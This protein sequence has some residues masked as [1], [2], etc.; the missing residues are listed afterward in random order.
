MSKIKYISKKEDYV[1]ND[2]KQSVIK[3]PYIIPEYTGK[4]YKNRMLRIAF[5]M[6]VEVDGKEVPVPQ[7]HAELRFG[8]QNIETLVEYN[9]EEI[10][11]VQAL[12][13]GWQYN[14]EEITKWGKPNFERGIGYIDSNQPDGLYFRDRPEQILAKDFILNAVFIEGKP[15]G[16]HF[17]LEEKTNE[18]KE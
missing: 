7:G 13:Q 2:G 14:P 11:V 3:N 10:E 6:Y 16:E 1:L 8:K 5:N 4:S 18:E 15:L 17:E 12:Q 9:G